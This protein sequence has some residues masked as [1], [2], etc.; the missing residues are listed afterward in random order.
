MSQLLGQTPSQTVGPFYTL[1]LFREGEN[2]LVPPGHTGRIVIQGRVLD[3]DRSPIEDGLLEIWQA[4]S[5]GRYHHPDDRRDLALDNGFTGFGRAITD[6]ETGGYT[7][8]TL[9]PGP[10]PDV[11]G[12][13]QAPHISLIVQG[14]GMLN[15]VFT[16]IYF[17]DEKEANRDDLILRSV[18]AER[19]GSLIAELVD[20][21]EPRVYRFDVLFQGDDETVFFDF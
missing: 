1:R 3:G 13:S 19:R 14:R 17:S 7:F 8:E 21:G 10:V 12:A 20:D 15:P 9:K 4:N 11:E 6:F 5:V 2:I 18:P 16:R